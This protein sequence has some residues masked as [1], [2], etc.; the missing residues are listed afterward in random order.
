MRSEKDLK[1]NFKD[2]KCSLTPIYK[3]QKQQQLLSQAKGESYM[4]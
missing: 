1:K 2:K 3:I 4:P